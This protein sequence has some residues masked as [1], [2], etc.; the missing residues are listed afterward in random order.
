MSE[1]PPTHRAKRIPD[2]TPR[3]FVYASLAW[4]AA[5]V[6]VGTAL[7]GVMLEITALQLAGALLTVVAIAV[8]IVTVVVSIYKTSRGHKM[9]TW[10]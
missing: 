1:R 10:R 5:L 9:K 3:L 2:K 7:A 6:G 4:F 8:F